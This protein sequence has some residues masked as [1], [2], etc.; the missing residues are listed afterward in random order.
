MM[1]F[2]LFLMLLSACEIDVPLVHDPPKGQG[3]GGGGGAVDAGNTADAGDPANAGRRCQANQDCGPGGLYCVK[4]LR[5]C[6]G[7]GVCDRMQPLRCAGASSLAYEPVCGCDG[8]TYFNSCLAAARGVPINAV[9]ECPP[10]QGRCFDHCT[11]PGFCTRL[12]SSCD[13]GPDLCYVLPPSCP[14]LAARSCRDSR[15]VDLCQSIPNHQG[16]PVGLG[17]P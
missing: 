10:A 8:V 4:T 17:C 9:G 6:G 3:A 7:V 5:D 13:P 11:P 1:R 15:C 2:G 14:D 12:S 16:G